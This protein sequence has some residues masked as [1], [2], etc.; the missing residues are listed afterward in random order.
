CGTSRQLDVRGRRC[1]SR[2]RFG[3]HGGGCG[4]GGRRSSC[5]RRIAGVVCGAIGCGRGSVGVR[6]CIKG[7]ATGVT[8]SQRG[9]PGKPLR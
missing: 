6:G 2:R 8:G 5:L 3:R 4:M 9:L 1:G 7:V